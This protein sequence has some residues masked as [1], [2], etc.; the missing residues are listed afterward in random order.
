MRG[1]G[2]G[3]QREEIHRLREK[4]DMSTKYNKWTCLETRAQTKQLFLKKLWA[5]NLNTY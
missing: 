3:I 5:G 2:K 4:W 1:G